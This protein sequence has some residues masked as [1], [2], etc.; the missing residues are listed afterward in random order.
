[1]VYFLTLPMYDVL[2]PSSL[3]SDSA[4]VRR[5]RTIYNMIPGLFKDFLDMYDPLFYMGGIA[6]TVDYVHFHMPDRG[7]RGNHGNIGHLAPLVDYLHNH[8]SHYQ[9]CPT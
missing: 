7:E 4:N 3:P 2:E 8:V 5:T 6:A 1:M 9:S